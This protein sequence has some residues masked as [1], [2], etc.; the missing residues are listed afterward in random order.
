[1]SIEQTD[2]AGRLP[3]G[4][5][6]GLEAGEEHLFDRGYKA[7]ATRP[8]AAPWRVTVHKK[9]RFIDAGPG[10]VETYFFDDSTSPPV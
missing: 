9:R 3:Y 10:R 2:Y 6:V 8:L 5:W 4:L 1:M 7:I